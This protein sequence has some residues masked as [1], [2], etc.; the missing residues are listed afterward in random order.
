[1]GRG[2]IV[3]QTRDPIVS[4]AATS[5]FGLRAL[6]CRAAARM[7]VPVKRSGGPAWPT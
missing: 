6:I 4:S 3:E 5:A 2:Q 1:V 7:I